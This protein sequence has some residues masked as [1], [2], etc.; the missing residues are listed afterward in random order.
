[1]LQ[2]LSSNPNKDKN[3]IVEIKPP[4]IVIKFNRPK[5]YNAF[6]MDMYLTL[7]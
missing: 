4:K 3:M 5:R 1:M 2:I 7:T 6:S